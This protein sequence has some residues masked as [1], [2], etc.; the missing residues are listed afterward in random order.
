MRWPRQHT[1]SSLSELMDSQPDAEST[2][3]TAEHPVITTRDTTESTDTAE[4]DAGTTEAEANEADAD[5]D[6]S[7]L[8]DEDYLPQERRGP[9]RLTIALVAVLVLAVGVLGGVWVQKQLGTTASA[10]GFGPGAGA[11]AGAGGTGQRGYGGTGTGAGGTGTGAGGTGG[12]GTGTGGA[13]TGGDTTGGTG[14]G[15]STNG[16]GTAAAPAVVGTVTTA[17]KKSLVVTD[18]GGTKH[19][20]TLT[21]AT[22]VTTAYTHG[23]LKTGDT[24]AVAGKAAADGSVA[25]TGITVT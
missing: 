21:D 16:S 6:G 2:V 1:D 7:F 10:S 23:A 15:G 20:V 14:T 11:G 18:L 25:A 9:G 12:T 5:A 22:T 17:G 4:A 13:G 3:T 24:V 8:D 19:T